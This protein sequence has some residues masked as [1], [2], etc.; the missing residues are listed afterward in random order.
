MANPNI[1]TQA[2]I[3]QVKPAQFLVWVQYG[4]TPAQVDLTTTTLTDA[5]AMVT[6][7]VNAAIV[8]N[9]HTQ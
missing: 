1:L 3:E 2:R 7:M 9:D 4:F 6:T 5:I 8:K